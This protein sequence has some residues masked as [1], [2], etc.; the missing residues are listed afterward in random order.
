MIFISR[1][2]GAAVLIPATAPGTPVPAQTCECGRLAEPEAARIPLPP[3]KAV[4]AG[5]GKLFS[6][7][8]TS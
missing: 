5:S 6:I 2:S 1:S 3:C 4:A 7:L 8:G